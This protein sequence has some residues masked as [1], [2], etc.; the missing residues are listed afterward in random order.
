M[1]A[2][3]TREATT[4]LRTSWDKADWIKQRGVARGLAR[5]KDEPV[6]GVSWTR[7]RSAEGRRT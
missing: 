6:R 1:L 3:S 7:K 5:R 4:L 2:D